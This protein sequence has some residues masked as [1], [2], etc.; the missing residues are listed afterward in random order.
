MS[1]QREWEITSELMKS[2]S[3]MEVYNKMIEQCIKCEGGIY[4]NRWKYKKFLLFKEP[5]FY[6]LDGRVGRDCIIG[7]YNMYKKENDK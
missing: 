1:S 3:D 7:F 5:R 6:Y 4:L 2:L